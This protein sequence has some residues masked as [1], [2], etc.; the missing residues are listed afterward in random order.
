MLLC[1]LLLPLSLPLALTFIVLRIIPK[2]KIIIETYSVWLKR[3]QVNTIQVS[4]YLF[5]AGFGF[6]MISYVLDTNLELQSQPFRMLFSHVDSKRLKY[7]IY[8][9]TPEQK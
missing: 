6:V 5:T 1:L 8:V 2:E 9:S 3:I 7:M 4:F